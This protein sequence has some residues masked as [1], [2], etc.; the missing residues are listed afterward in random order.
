MDSNNDLK[1]LILHFTTGKAWREGSIPTYVRGEGVYLW[2]ENGRRH[3]DGLAGLFVVQIGHGRSDLAHAAAKQMQDLAYTPTWGAA[4]P[5]AVEASKLIASLAPGDLDAVFF[6]SSGSEAVE[7]AI[8]FARQYHAGRG[9]PKKTM[10]ISRNLAYHGTTMGALSAT[11]LD[12]IRQPFQPLLPGFVKVPNTLG[13]LDGVA[14]AK[15]V[16]DAI[17]EHGAGNVG[18]IIAE[19]VQ[20]GGGAIVPPDGY[21]RELRRIADRY[22]VLLM[23]DE[24]ING[25]GRLGTWFGSHYVE[26]VPDLLS[27]AKGATSGYAPVGG[28]L[29]RR[30]RVDELFDSPNGTFT[31]GATWGGHPVAMA[32]TLANITAMRDENVIDNVTANEPYFKSRLEGLRDAHDIVNDIRGAGY[33]YAIELCRSRA[34]GSML[35]AEE[36]KDHVA[37]LM[38]RLIAEAGLVIR[39]DDRGEPKLMLSP[40]LI[41]TRTEIDELIDGVDQV[42]DRAAPTLRGV[43]L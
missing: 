21:W 18:L 8:K 7:S 14:A 28:L 34:E 29:V 2:D 1:H 27:F 35:T 43:G 42:L 12:G 3:L 25:F 26:V 33:F 40:P 20:N 38:P 37:S 24:V 9:N 30:S 16:E 36:A 19:P 4:H 39:A 31:H 13:V 5:P 22:D 10:V 6:V 17:L 41:A 15:P 11:G 32:V 23:A